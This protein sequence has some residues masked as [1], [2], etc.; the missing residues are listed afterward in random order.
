MGPDKKVNCAAKQIVQK[1]IILCL[2]LYNAI[3]QSS[4]EYHYRQVQLEL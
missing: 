3:V 4:S 1:N 2:G